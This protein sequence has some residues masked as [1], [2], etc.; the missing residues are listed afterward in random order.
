MVS[1]IPH[2][3]NASCLL[4][5]TVPAQYWQRSPGQVGFQD[6]YGSSAVPILPLKHRAKFTLPNSGGGAVLTT[7][8]SLCTTAGGTP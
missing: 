3:A 1:P 7:D 6:T 2:S 8:L 4:L 5:Q